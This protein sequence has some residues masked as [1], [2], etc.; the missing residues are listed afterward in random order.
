[1]SN[2]IA[3][4]NMIDSIDPTKNT[5][6][7]KL[8]SKV[9]IEE[10][11]PLESTWTWKYKPKVQHT[12][13]QQNEED[14]LSSF[15]NICKI[16]SVEMFWS[17]KNNIHS[18]SQMHYGSIY[19]FF[20]DDIN[21]SWE[22]EKNKDGCSYAFYFVKERMTEKDLD[23]VFESVLLCLIGEFGNFSEY[24]NGATFERKFKGDKLIVWCNAH[25]QEMLE[26]LR[27]EMLPPSVRE[28]AT[29]KRTELNNRRYKVTIKVID[30]QSELE[31]I[32][33]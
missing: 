13:K 3:K 21:P 5:P 10:K 24:V 12:K 1:M 7:D 26:A 25:S 33:N 2:T 32:N 4:D 31:R 9:V 18:W 23:D 19:S 17:V 20:R 11:H 30:H 6:I 14:W 16:G 8:E 27:D 15:E 22:D 29:L 28:Y